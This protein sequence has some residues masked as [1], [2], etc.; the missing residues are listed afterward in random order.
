[1]RLF[2]GIEMP[3]AARAAAAAEAADCRRQIAEAARRAAIKW[4]PPGN[5]HITLWFLGEL[6]DRRAT[7]LVSAL[8]PPF[9]TP[10]FGVELQGMGA[11]PPSGGLRVI[12]LGLVEGRQAV[13]DLHGELARRLPALGFASDRRGYSPHVTLARVKDI[14]RADVAAVRSILQRRHRRVAAFDVAAVTLFRSRTSGS[15][16]QYESLLRVPLR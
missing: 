3:P 16:S 8:A 6:D 2:I 10:R 11:Y 15:G 4:V 13:I 14:R 12:W 7:D 5:L 1:M 9:E